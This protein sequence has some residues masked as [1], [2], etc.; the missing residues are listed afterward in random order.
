MISLKINHLFFT[1]PQTG[2]DRVEIL[3]D[4]HFTVEKGEFLVILGESGCGK[5]T[6][7]NLLAGLLKPSAGEIICGE[8]QL[9]QLDPSIALLF[10]EST[11][12]PWL[13]VRD[14]IA[15]GC[16]LRRD[17]EDLRQRVKQY[18]EMMGLLPFQS[19]FPQA[20]SVGLSKRVD[21]A[22]AL[23]GRPQALLLDEPFAPLDYFNKAR[24]RNELMAIWQRERMTCVFVTHD[25]DEA[26]QLGQ[27]IMM[28]SNRPGRIRYQ[29]NIPFAYPR[30][31][32]DIAFI[33]MKKE[34]LGQFGLISHHDS[35]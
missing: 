18:M 21:L 29:L 2:G 15:F 24:L 25:I 32:T 10:Q 7:L 4:I 3:T 11:L 5:S 35:A 26:L 34:L 28:M 9:T 8:R 27:R 20:L 6:L 1:Q 30:S 19:Y 17:T 16:R 31:P 22:R 23:I 14:N 13:N 33:E 12:L